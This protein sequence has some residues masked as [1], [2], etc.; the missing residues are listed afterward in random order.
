MAG[1]LVFQMWGNAVRG[2]IDTTSVFWWWGW[3]WFNPGSESEHGPLLLGLAVWLGW[4]NLRKNEVRRKKSEG[5]NPTA[6]SY[7][8]GQVTIELARMVERRERYEQGLERPV[9]EPGP[10]SGAGALSHRAGAR[11][12]CMT[13]RD[14]GW[15]N[16]VGAKRA[17]CVRP[18]LCV[19]G[20]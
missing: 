12:A 1:A 3:Q 16:L 6:F 7:L 20:S 17:P 19:G 9:L 2:Y 11:E 8:V 13:S 5:L 14:R 4:R 18:P 10:R 15:C